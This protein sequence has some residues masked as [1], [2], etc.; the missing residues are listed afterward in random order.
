MS[1]TEVAEIVTNVE[2]KESPATVVPKL[3][4]HV[5]KSREMKDS[6]FTPKMLR[7]EFEKYGPVVEVFISK[8]PDG[9]HERHGKVIM[10]DEKSVDKVLAGRDK[11]DNLKVTKGLLGVAMYDTSERGKQKK[12][13][14]PI[15]SLV[16]KPLPKDYT[17]AQLKEYFAK[18]GQ[19]KGYYI[20]NTS[21]FVIYEDAKLATQ[22]LNDFIDKKVVISFEKDDKVR[23]EHYVRKK[24]NSRHN[25]PK[26]WVPRGR[27]GGHSGRGRGGSRGRGGFG[28]GRGFGRGSGRGGGHGKSERTETYGHHPWQQEGFTE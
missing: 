26:D 13:E 17:E 9:T 10:G 15:T 20:K 12:P 25:S 23:L 4:L 19:L 7:E 2:S 18:F 11:D 21:G 22:L 24:F 27:G 3:K 8:R 28:R 1:H 6:D 16:V 5:R 14:K